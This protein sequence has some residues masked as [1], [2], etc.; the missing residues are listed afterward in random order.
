[1]FKKL[2]NLRSYL[3]K[4]L[5]FKNKYKLNFMNDPCTALKFVFFTGLISFY[6]FYSCSKTVILSFLKRAGTVN[7]I[8]A[9]NGGKRS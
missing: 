5:K 3:R 9:E 2:I 8:L 1:M 6:N 7:V 4:R